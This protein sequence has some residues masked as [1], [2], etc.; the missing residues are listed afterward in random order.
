ME[1]AKKLFTFS[2]NA[3]IVGMDVTTSEFVDFDPEDPYSAMAR[4][5]VYSSLNGSHTRRIEHALKHAKAAGAHG[6]VWFCH[7]GCRRTMIAANE[8]K[9]RFEEA[10]IP[11]LILNGDSVDNTGGGSEQAG[12]RLDAFMEMLNI[13]NE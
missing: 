13:R 4:C 12:T 1:S 3:Q 11:V 5:L 2:E 9:R 8:G 10:G 6:A 7:W